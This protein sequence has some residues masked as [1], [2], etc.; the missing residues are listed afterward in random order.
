MEMPAREEFLGWDEEQRTSRLGAVAGN[1]RLCVLPTGR[2]H[3]LASAALA[4]MLRRLVPCQNSHAG[5][6]LVF[7]AIESALA[8]DPRNPGQQLH[9]TAECLRRVLSDPIP[10]VSGR[11]C[12]VNADRCRPDLG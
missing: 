2:Q 9:K 8:P 4:A 3:N 1:Q 11:H 7:S 10:R 5:S 12:P 6:E